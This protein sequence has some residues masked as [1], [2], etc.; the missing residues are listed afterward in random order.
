M[1]LRLSYTTD[2]MRMIHWHITELRLLCDYYLLVNCW[3]LFHSAAVISLHTGAYWKCRMHQIPVIINH[4]WHGSEREAPIIWNRIQSVRKK[5]DVQL[6]VHATC[7]MK[8]NQIQRVCSVHAKDTKK[9][10]Y[11]DFLFYIYTTQLSDFKNILYYLFYSKIA[12]GPSHRRARRRARTGYRLDRRGNCRIWKEITITW[13][14]SF[15]SPP[16]TII[17]NTAHPAPPLVAGMWAVLNSGECDHDDD[18]GHRQKRTQ[19]LP[20]L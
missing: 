9:M 8:K 2:W 16:T 1:Y 10:H 14:I 11:L 20:S 13:L 17:A 12:C 19:P 3:L 6:Q 15:L 18:D 5:D 4:R 7:N